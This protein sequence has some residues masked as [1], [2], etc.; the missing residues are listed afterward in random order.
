VDVVAVVAAVV[1]VVLEEGVTGVAVM[2][3][4]S[5]LRL[6]LSMVVVSV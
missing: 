2:T 5:S 4:T 1:V 6:S 3:I